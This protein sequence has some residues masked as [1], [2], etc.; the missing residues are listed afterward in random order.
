MTKILLEGNEKELNIDID[1]LID[2]IEFVRIMKKEITSIETSGA[3]INGLII[4]G[5]YKKYNTKKETV[6]ADTTDP[7]N[8]K[9]LSSHQ[10]VKIT[11]EDYD[12]ILNTT[13]NIYGI[14]NLNELKFLLVKI[15]QI[16]KQYKYKEDKN[17]KKE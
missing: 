11:K 8:W 5:K 4:R 12:E 15:G 7:M 9:I 14:S 13:D 16:L 1:E 6:T 3:I 2:L 17:A 10:M